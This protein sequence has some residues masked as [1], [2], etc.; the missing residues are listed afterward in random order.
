MLNL[1]RL[2]DIVAGTTF[3]RQ[4][5]HS[6]RYGVGIDLGNLFAGDLLVVVMVAVTIAASYATYQLIELPGQQAFRHLADRLFGPAIR[7]ME[8]GQRP[9]QP[10]LR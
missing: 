3:V 1:T 7:P 9:L 2:L 8:S 5:G 6:D 4:V 10:A